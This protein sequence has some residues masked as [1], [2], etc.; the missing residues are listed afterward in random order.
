MT[1]H[2][3]LMLAVI[4]L[5]LFLL[6]AN[7]LITTYNARLNIYEQLKV[8]AQD[9]ATSLG[10]SMSQ[11]A[12]N[13]DNV[14]M[15][16]MVDAIFDRGY[17]RRITYRDIEGNEKI[18]KELSLE[19][20]DVPDWFVYWLPL[21]EPQGVAEVS[22]GWNQLGEIEVVSHPG[23]AYRDLWRSFKEQ[24]WLYLVTAVMCYGLLGLG[25]RY[26]LEPLRRVE[27]QADAICR[28][29]F[30]VQDD[31]PAIPELRRMVVAMNRMVAKVKS[32]FQ[33]QLELN[34]HL[35]QQLNTDP[36]TGLDNRQSFDKRFSSYLSSEKSASSG[37]LMLVQ[38][39]NLQ[40][41][42]MGG[43]RQEGDDYLC[44]VAAC[45]TAA[46]GDNDSVIVSRHAGADF[47]VFVPAVAESESRELMDHTYSALQ[48]MDWA[49]DDMQSVYIGALFIPKLQE[50]S[51]FMALADTALSQAQNEQKSGCYWH[52][53]DKAE[54]SLSASEWAE[55]IKTGIEEQAL[56]FHYQPVWKVLHGEKSLLFN[57]VMIRMNV[58]GEER[59]A[60]FFMPMATRLNMLPAIDTLVLKQLEE[61][62]DNLPEHL[63]INV[64][65]ASIENQEFVERVKHFLQQYPG[66]AKRLTFELPA[67]ALSFA[68]KAIRS[69]ADI[70]KLNGASLSLHHFGKGS[71]EF[72]Y[73]QTLPV[74]Y[75]KIDRFFIQQVEKDPDTRFFVRSLV[76][77]AESCDVTILAE[78]VETAEQW[79]ALI[80]LGVMGGQGY[81][82]GKPS[83]QAVV[84]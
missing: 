9:T 43:G 24:I 38:A 20:S 12:I 46:L 56:L 67:N 78:G 19:M 37:L 72:D 61:Q 71:S 32:M 55:L 17:Y 51:N 34:D 28:R 25:L 27:E 53:V 80:E 2:R 66:L 49:N 30:P 81:W 47:A 35:Y 58:E 69:F 29:E 6:I 79:E 11:A 74:D 14:Q 76:T 39:G 16:L 22:S 57:E 65:V 44:G 33:H 40:A 73:L 13:Q 64:S 70:V 77:I 41:I 7:L 59:P 45:L 50:A 75:L 3:R 84:G 68:K 36:V 21:P 62:Q 10:F 31:L 15:T 48:E 83:A 4:G 1:L 18:K 23:F 26:V 52:K 54:R 5:I 60:G 42:N 82:L 63:C 8:H